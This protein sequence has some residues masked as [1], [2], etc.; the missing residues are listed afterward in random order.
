MPNIFFKLNIKGFA[1]SWFFIC[2]HFASSKYCLKNQFINFSNFIF[3][4]IFPLLEK[5]SPHHY[6]EC[7]RPS[8][9]TYC[10]WLLLS[11]LIFSLLPFH[12]PFLLLTPYFSLVTFPFLFSLFPPPFFSFPFHFS[13]SH[14]KSLL[15]KRLVIAFALVLCISS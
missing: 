7:R 3:S 1:L 11:F 4:F 10:Y 12:F 5:S 15:F 2:S 13:I 8:R 9:F 14:C 6:T